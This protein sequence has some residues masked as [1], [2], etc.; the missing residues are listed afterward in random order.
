M[1]S[2]VKTTLASA[3]VQWNDMVFSTVVALCC[4]TVVVLRA[5]K[6]LDWCW[7]AYFLVSVSHNGDC[8]QAWHHVTQQKDFESQCQILLRVVLIG[9]IS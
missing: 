9:V 2:S 5:L 4:G 1:P 6:G 8:C 3:G 7:M